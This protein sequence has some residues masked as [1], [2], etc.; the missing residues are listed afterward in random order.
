LI[1]VKLLSIFTAVCL[2]FSLIVN[3]QK[4][5]IGI[6]KGIAMFLK[7][8]P[9]LLGMLALISVVLFLIPNETLVHYMGEGAGVKGWITAALLGSVALIPGFIAY[10]LCGILISN[11][12]A[13]SVI[14]VFITTLMMTGFLTL[15][16]EARFFG[17]RV[18]IIRNLVSLAAALLIGL[19]MG[20]FL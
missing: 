17:W 15:P 2:I 8:L 9:V 6:K 18:S 13:Y 16:V 4:T 20:F 12:V 7:L 1:V 14:A 5:W 3:R 10:P 19:I 11:G